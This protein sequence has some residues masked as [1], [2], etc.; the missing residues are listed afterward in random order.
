LTGGGNQFVGD[1]EP[2]VLRCD[3]GQADFGHIVVS[4][5]TAG[6]EEWYHAASS[7]SDF[8]IE[9]AACEGQKFQESHD[10]RR[11]NSGNTDSDKKT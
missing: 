1:S 11:D 3:R 9:Y 8:L 4:M 10:V 7:F 5:P 6:R 2:L